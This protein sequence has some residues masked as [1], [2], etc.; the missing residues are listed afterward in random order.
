MCPSGIARG[1]PEQ[2]GSHEQFHS[3]LKAHTARPPAATARAQQRRFTTF[4][5]EYNDERP[6]EALHDETPA[7]HY[8]PS[9][10]P[11]PRRV[12]PLEY[13]GHAEVR[14]REQQRVCVVDE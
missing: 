8:Q 7:M 3:V 6:H 12:P 9:P 1:H 5:R 14:F 2:N 10:R 11:L 4:C 13:P